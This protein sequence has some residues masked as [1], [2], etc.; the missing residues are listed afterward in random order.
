M[1]NS[2]DLAA[3]IGPTMIA[4]GATEALNFS[5]FSGQIA[6]VVYLNGAI[7]FVVGLALMRVH[8][9]WVWAW[10]VLITLTGWALLLGGLYR[11]IAP[12][13]PQAPE[14][15]ASFVMFAAL[16]LIGAF[17]S[18]KGYGPENAPRVERRR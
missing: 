15:G 17:L 18:Y 11:M 6:P 14:G 7:L 13:A 5:M 8:N 4:L 2:R 12:A 16:A 10:P 1:A 3:L 9:R